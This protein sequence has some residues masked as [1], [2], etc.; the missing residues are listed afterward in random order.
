MCINNE[1]FVK[2]EDQRCYSSVAGI[3][4]VHEITEYDILH[5]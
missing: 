3:Y 1:D 5:S 4:V 2:A